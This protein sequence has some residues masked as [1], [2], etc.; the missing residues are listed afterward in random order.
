LADRIYDDGAVQD[1]FAIMDLYDRQ[2]AAAEAWD[3]EAYD[4]TFAAV[5][6]ID[7]RDFDQP[8]RAYPEYRDWLASLRTVMVAA[9]RITGGLRLHLDGDRATTRVP[10]VCYVTMAFEGT[11]TLTYTGL[12]Y[13]DT[14]QRTADGWRIVQRYEELAWSGAPGELA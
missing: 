13:N 4:T 2:L 1:R 6:E 11:R 7:L 3:L 10:V 14:L 8:V 12:F 5:A 9:Q